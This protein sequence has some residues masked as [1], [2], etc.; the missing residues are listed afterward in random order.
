MVK[1]DSIIPD[2]QEGSREDEIYMTRL[3]VFGH[4]VEYFLDHADQL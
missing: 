2:F 4:V 1:T 3:A